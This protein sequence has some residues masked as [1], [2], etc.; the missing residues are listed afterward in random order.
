MQPPTTEEKH[1]EKN[2]NKE[3]IKQILPTKEKN[4]APAPA[5]TSQ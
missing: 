4:A 1:A 3:N 2:P 5:K